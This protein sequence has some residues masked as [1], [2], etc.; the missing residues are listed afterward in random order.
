MMENS[1][2]QAI[3]FD[4]DGALYDSVQMDIRAITRMLENDLGWD[5]KDINVHDFLGASSRAVLERIA[6]ERVEEL[7]AKWLHYQDELREQTNL[8]PDVRSTLTRLKAAGYK[9][10]VVTSQNKSELD[11][12]RKYIKIDD[13][14]QV[15]VSASD[16]KNPKPHPAPVTKALALLDVSA[17]TAMMVGDSI[18]DLQAGRAAGTKVGA[19]LWG[20]HNQETLLESR[21]DY[22]FK[23][24]SDLLI[25]V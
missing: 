13:L 11:A 17:E 15:W 23:K 10:G 20:A 1:Q 22:I 6:P 14:I 18:S 4:L 3:L 21:P 9:L 5:V 12:T 2:L 25:L 8:F 7:L 19:V 24:I 16:T